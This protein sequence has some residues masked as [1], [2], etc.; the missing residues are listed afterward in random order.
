[1][2]AQTADDVA[3]QTADYVADDQVQAE[4][5]QQAPDQVGEQQRA[6]KLGAK[7]KRTLVPDNTMS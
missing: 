2:A 6:P 3:A 5:E 7:L 4:E 1:M